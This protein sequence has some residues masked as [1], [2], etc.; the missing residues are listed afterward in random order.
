V[1]TSI[2]VAAMLA[3]GLWVWGQFVTVPDDAVEVE[4]VGQQWHWSFRYPGADGKLGKTDVRKSTV[5]NPF[6]MDPEDPAGQDDILVARPELRL[7]LGQPVKLL[8]RSKDVL[9]D[10][11]VAEFRVKMDL[12]PGMVTYA[13]LTPTRTGTFDVLCEEFCGIAHH[14]MRARVVVDTA[15]T[16]QQ[17]LSQQ[18]TFA[19]REA[20]AAGSAQTGQAQY[21]VCSACHGAQGEGNPAMNA[22]RLAGLDGWYIKQQL[23]NYQQGKRGAH[24]DDTFGQQMAPMA[25]TLPDEAAMDNV[26]AYLASLPDPAVT[27]TVS[28]DSKRGRKLYSVCGSCH[29][30]QGQGVWSLNAPRI[31]GM[32]DWYLARQLM[33]FKDGV[34]GAHPEDIYGEQ[35][36]FMAR[37]LADEQAVNDIVAYINSLD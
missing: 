14:A 29:G 26:I 35:M 31:A 1:I 9:H 17:W 5:A 19:E 11:A 10:F 34:R 30:D 27:D 4:I 6:G 32:S 37:T 18:P 3:P 12:V 28:G 24:P 21:A 8:M 25:A 16:F 15:D 23:R 36:A 2:G 20:M 7:Q 13:W 33:N 22:P